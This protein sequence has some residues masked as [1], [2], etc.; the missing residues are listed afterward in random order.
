MARD[1]GRS[2]RAESGGGKDQ[3]P[4]EGQRRERDDE[5]DDRAEEPYVSLDHPG[6]RDFR[7][8]LGAPAQLALQPALPALAPPV[9][10]RGA[11]ILGPFADHLLLLRGPARDGLL[12]AAQGRPQML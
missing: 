12:R 1:N 2:A 9:G 6:V 4:E 7:F 10:V 5:E 8:A 11:E 3:P